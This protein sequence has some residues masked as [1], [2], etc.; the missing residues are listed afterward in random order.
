MGKVIWH[1]P[2]LQQAHNIYDYYAKLS[3]VVALG[4]LNDIMNAPDI[5]ETA[6]ESGAPEPAFEGLTPTRRFLL[7]RRIYKIVYFVLNEECHITMI[8][9]TRN[10]PALFKE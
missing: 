8:W 2:A 7:V 6:P 10:N 1:T 4:V 9:N 3:E 5:L